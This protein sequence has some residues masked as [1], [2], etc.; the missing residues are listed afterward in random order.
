MPS[1]KPAVARA[2]PSRSQLAMS[3]APTKTNWS[4]A[5]DGWSCPETNP[6]AA[7]NAAAASSIALVSMR[8]S[9][10]STGRTVSSS[11]HVCHVT[12]TDM[13][14]AGRR[15]TGSLPEGRVLDRFV[16]V[17]V[18]AVLL[19]RAVRPEVP[20][21]SRQPARNRSPT[22]RSRRVR[23]RRSR[24]RRACLRSSRQHRSSSRNRRRRR[25][26]RNTPASVR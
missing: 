2:P 5:G 11:V 4:E 18:I 14:G 6:E 26:S 17:V 8:Q 9:T 23:L 12:V 19:L 16:R 7:I 15:A 13:P 3:P 24:L 1:S 10:S 25:R 20:P 22:R 21:K